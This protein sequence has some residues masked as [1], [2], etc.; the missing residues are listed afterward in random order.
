[1]ELDEGRVGK[2]SGRGGWGEGGLFT[3]SKSVSPTSPHPRR[4]P[5][6]RDE[7]CLVSQLDK[8]LSIYYKILH[9][10]NYQNEKKILFLKS[11]FEDIVNHVYCGSLD[12][13]IG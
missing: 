4:S 11:K 2:R 10:L 6:A 8:K 3:F 12:Q 9:S 13:H 5:G 1:M 7:M